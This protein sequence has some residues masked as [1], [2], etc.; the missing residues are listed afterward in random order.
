MPVFRISK[1][2]PSLRDAGGA[3]TREEWTSHGDIGKVFDGAE[4]TLAEYLVV[5]ARYLELLDKFLGW[6]RV[7]K[8]KVCGMEVN[9]R[10]SL[11]RCRGD[12]KQGL[13]EGV[14]LEK[15]EI[16][17]VARL[18]LRE[19]LWCR[20]EGQ[21]FYVHFGYDFYMYIGGVALMG[22]PPAVTG[23]FVEMIRES[24]HGNDGS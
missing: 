13:S 18:A 22:D 20:L 6:G 1:Y 5:E 9:D 3:Y 17:E 16:L 4:L 8:L 23:L 10:A 12:A 7:K 19:V 21:E 24:P 15:A 2:D 11:Q 14:W